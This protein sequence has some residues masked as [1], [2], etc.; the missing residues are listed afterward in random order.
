M[1]ELNLSRQQS[2]H[3]FVERFCCYAVTTIKDDGL[4]KIN[5]FSVDKA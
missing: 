1:I 4:G 3:A 5:K 2:M